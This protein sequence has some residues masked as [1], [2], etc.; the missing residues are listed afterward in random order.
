MA[1]GG[2]D[3]PCL[4]SQQRFTRRLRGG[5]T[6]V[7]C[8][9]ATAGTDAQTSPEMVFEEL[10]VVQLCRSQCSGIQRDMKALDGVLS[11]L[12]CPSVGRTES[13]EPPEH[14]SQVLQWVFGETV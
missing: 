4:S 12:D 2:S 6:A 8:Q 5:G 9:T 1:E 3:P 13:S 7:G 10:Q 11:S 14:G